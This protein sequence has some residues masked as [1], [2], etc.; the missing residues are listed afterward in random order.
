M[1]SHH[2]MCMLSCKKS[3][4]P[5][6]NVELRM[7]TKKFKILFLQTVITKQLMVKLITFYFYAWTFFIIIFIFS[8]NLNP[9]SNQNL[10]HAASRDFFIDLDLDDSVGSKQSSSELNKNNNQDTSVNGLFFL[11]CFEIFFNLFEK[12]KP[13]WCYVILF[14][15]DRSFT[16]Q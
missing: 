5:G 15:F 8:D 7:L 4:F 3:S 11:L 14:A 9:L 6:D 16:K 10:T 12:K 2:E 13:N 1:K